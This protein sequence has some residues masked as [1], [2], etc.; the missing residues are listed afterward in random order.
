[1][2]AQI[3]FENFILVSFIIA[4]IIPLMVI[5]LVQ[6]NE[7]QQVI[8]LSTATNSLR[9]IGEEVDTIYMAGNGSKK[10]IFVRFPNNLKNITTNQ[11]EIVFTM[12]DGQQVVYTCMA[13]V[14]QQDD[15]SS[16]GIGPMYCRKK[17]DLIMDGLRKV[18]II[19][20]NNTHIRIGVPKE[21]I[22][23]N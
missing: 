16:N 2:K 18:A 17:G 8:S 13:N 21:G 23:C 15:P 19:Y 3:V 5:Y 22:L 20:K 6:T 10:V 7:K 12:S 4:M 11:K 9:I 14:Y 1:M